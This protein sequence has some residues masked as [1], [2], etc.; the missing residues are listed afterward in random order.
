MQ[1]PPVTSYTGDFLRP[2]GDVTTVLDAC[3][4]DSQDDHLFPI[5]SETSWF[6]RDP[7][8]RTIPFNQEI[9]T[10]QFQG[11]AA[12][13][14]YMSFDLG[15]QAAGDLIHA[16]G[17]QIRLG[18][19]L[20]PGIIAALQG[21]TIRY[22][23][24][25]NAWTYTN[26]IGRAL[27]D[28]AEFV[29][30]D[31][32]I[33]RLDSVANDVILKLFPNTNHSF[34]FGR[35][36]TGIASQVELVT[37]PSTSFSQ[38]PTGMF[39]PQR[40]WSTDRG[41]I[42]CLIPFFFS[43]S[44]RQSAFPLLSV[45]EGRTR[46]NIQLRNFADIVRSVSGT[47]ASCT[48]SPLGETFNFSTVA[49]GTTTAT[50]PVDPPPFT[51][52]RLIVFSTLLGAEPRQPY[53]RKPFE[54][55]Y[56]ELVPFPFSQPLKYAV[57]MTNSATD[58]VS[59]QLPIEANG[60]V[61]ELIWVIRRKA[62]AI[63]NDWFNYSQYTETQISANPDLIP[64]EP[65]VEATININAKQFVR[66]PGSWFRAQ[67]A[68]RHAGGI[69]PYNAYVYGFSFAMSPSAHQPSG[70]ANL[71]RAQAVRLDLTVRVPPAV[72]VPSGFDQDISQ[73]W[74][75]FV[76]TLGINWLRFENGMC[77]RIFST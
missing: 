22:T 70:T 57:A 44:P 56:R 21:N 28:T 55:M 6:T 23:D 1:R 14:G 7:N 48:S 13:G 52:V 41:D 38:A 59:V 43:R 34:G 66:Q 2:R 5:N 40:P 64:V 46:I 35:D 10:F 3:D 16:V 32:T 49:G 33:E 37:P 25:T 36:G 4:R 69:T 30:D 73:T 29:V 8:R 18:H 54:V 26:G 68:R 39:D 75:V 24:P 77:G 76:Y 50:A 11:T 31:V 61:E 12:F 63:N 62:Q 58:S 42:F 27:I 67:M 74:E 51:D 47:R 60:P 71:S 45:R 53:I 9:Q 15:N 20:G 17:L 19:W 65:L 72:T